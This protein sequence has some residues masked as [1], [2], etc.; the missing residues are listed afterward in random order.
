MLADAAFE[1]RGA[2]PVRFLPRALLADHPRSMRRAVQTWRCCVAAQRGAHSSPRRRPRLDST[3]SV[4]VGGTAFKRSWL[5]HLNDVA[6][7]LRAFCPVEYRP[8]AYRGRAA[9]CGLGAVVLWST[10]GTLLLMPSTGARPHQYRDRSAARSPKGCTHCS[11]TS[12][13]AFRVL[14]AP[15]SICRPPTEHAC[16]AVRSAQ[17]EWLCCGPTRCAILPTPSAETKLHQ[18]RGRLAA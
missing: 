4:T 1:T 7:G 2:Q 3:N 17:L 9:Q 13:R 5:P 6:C 8:T 12:W 15:W 18:R 16:C 10:R 14:S 11:R